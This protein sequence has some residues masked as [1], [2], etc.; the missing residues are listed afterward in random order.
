[1]LANANPGLKKSG[2]R[3]KIRLDPALWPGG[4]EREGVAV[5]P[6]RPSPLFDQIYE[7][8]WAQIISGEI[9]PGTRLSDLDWS[10]RLNVSR[11]PVREAM[12]KLQQDGVLIP[13]SRGGYEL[14]E[15]SADDL[16]DLYRCRGAL[17]ALA[18][19][20]AAQNISDDEIVALRDVVERAK[21]ALESGDFDTV[22]NL[23]T[24]FHDDVIVSA[25]NHY[26]E[27]MLKDLRRM[28]L[29]ARHSLMRAVKTQPDSQLYIE[30]LQRVYDDHLSILDRIVARDEEGA[31]HLME[32]H[33]RTTSR[34]MIH[35][36]K[37]GE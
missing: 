27:R 6:S 37:R 23:N 25:R 1:M 5:Q 24:R 19:C 9:A 18:A 26:L 22:F 15:I 31:S 28:I 3:E 14:R 8:L 30:H 12:R 17:E 11:T 34:D 36:A 4:V 20:Q 33:I 35:L 10:A 13:L 16:N 32:Q 21:G 29:F 7:F 2:H